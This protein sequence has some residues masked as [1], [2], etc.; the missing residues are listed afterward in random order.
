MKRWAADFETTTQPDDCRVWAWGACSIDEKLN[1]D[2]GTNIG[3]FLDFAFKNP[4]EY[5][6]HNLKFDGK[7]ILP[8][9][10]A[11][12]EHNLYG[13]AFTYCSNSK[14]LEP[15]EF[16]TIIDE[17]LKF[18]EIK[19]C[20]KGKKKREYIVI[21]DSF[22]KLPFALARI[23]KDFG[24]REQK[25]EIDYD[26]YRAPDHELTE[27]EYR[28]LYNDCV[29]LAKALKIQFDN[30]NTGMTIGADA[31]SSYRKI[32]GKKYDL[33][34]PQV[35]TIM[36]S[37]IR[38]AY[39]GGYT[40]CDPRHRGEIV[41]EGIVLDVNSMYPYVMAA[42][43]MPVG[44]PIYFSG[45]YVNDKHHPLWVANIKFTF[46][47]KPDHVPCIQIKNSRFYSGNT[48]LD[49]S[50]GVVSLWVSSVDWALINDQYDVDVY[51]YVE[52]YKMAALTGIFDDY[53]DYWMQIKENSTGALR[54]LAKLM[55]NNLYGKYG[56]NPDRGKRKPVLDNDGMMHYPLDCKELGEPVY[57]PIA[58]FV[59]AW[60]RDKMVRSAQACYPRFLYCDTDSLHILG[61]EIPAD[62]EIH[63][64]KLGCWD[65]EAQF[66]QAK[67]LRAKSYMERIVVGQTVMHD[68]R[69]R[70]TT[71]R[72]TLTKDVVTCAGMPPRVKE[73]CTFDNFNIG[74]T[75][76]ADD[77]LN[78]KPK[79]V[80]GGVVLT[81][82]PYSLHA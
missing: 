82:A 19:I 47:L 12:L 66:V 3:G 11:D 20:V 6:F 37:H 58:V 62:L 40:Y 74:L 73:I 56:T 10:L 61:R 25:L 79:D 68:R 55:L 36:D 24:I 7:F 26:A 49:E 42:R 71:R 30:G 48:Y 16:S 77:K 27:L 39:R 33:W 41:G 72:T 65:L 35:N 44:I 52:G 60:A 21:R 14:K 17:G 59:T 50:D 8:V 80:V 67:Y 76:S 32:V 81:P 63:P 23:A 69:H 34:F 64:T 28:Y 45:K 38:L 57:T 1:Y 78:L 75:V 51:E 13:R 31:L 43:P 9:L 15:G 29:I 22:K 5:Y 4:G 54:A 18:Y 53:I 46:K 70:A 2:C